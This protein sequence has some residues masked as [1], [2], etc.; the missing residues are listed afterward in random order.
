MKVLV[1]ADLSARSDRAVARGIQLARQLKAQLSVLTVIDADLPAELRTHTR[2]WAR[3]ALQREID[4]QDAVHASLEVVEG[5]PADRIL[6]VATGMAADLIVLGI[7][8]RAA[9][10]STITAVV[11]GTLLPVLMV[12]NEAARPYCTVVV[13]TDLSVRS[14]A[15]VRQAFHIAPGGTLHLV[16]AY[17]RPFPGYLTEDSTVNAFAYSERQQLDAF[18]E[19]EMD[20][21]DRRAQELGLRREHLESYL[22]EGDPCDVLVA[23][24]A[25]VGADLVVVASSPTTRLKMAFH[26]SVAERLLSVPPTDILVARPF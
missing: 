26:E 22:R 4:G 8:D 23:E 10:R 13:G 19:S 17:R 15:A 25:R 18:L 1:A 21:L 5:K 3:R 11:R 20:E 14:R 9:A 24:C 2:E 7:H 6:A 16:H 12:K